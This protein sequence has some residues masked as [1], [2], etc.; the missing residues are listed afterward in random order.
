MNRLSTWPLR[1]PPHFGI[2]VL[3]RGCL[4]GSTALSGGVRSGSVCEAL[5]S[6]DGSA[7]KPGLARQVGHGGPFRSVLAPAGHYDPP[8]L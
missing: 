5:E 2:G 1:F 3:G 8:S 6:R 4:G 7:L